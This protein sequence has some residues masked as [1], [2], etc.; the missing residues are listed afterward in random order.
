AEAAAPET[1][2]INDQGVVIGSM[3]R[4]LDLRSTDVYE[5]AWGVLCGVYQMVIAFGLFRASTLLSMRTK[6]DYLGWD[7]VFVWE[8]ALRGQI[9]QRE[10]VAL[11]RRFHA[12]ATSH[13]KTAT[14][15]KKWVEPVAKAGGTSFPHW[16][17]A[18]E[19]A[20]SLMATPLSPRERLRVGSL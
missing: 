15:L 7:F 3:E 11:L 1:K 6:P 13:V 10:G 4:T 16:T 12:G 19:R 18:Y 5:R 20:R 17:W 14:E 8:L 2:N 9:I